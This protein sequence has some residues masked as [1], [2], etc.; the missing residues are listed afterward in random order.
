MRTLALS[1]LDSVNAPSSV[2]ASMPDSA[3]VPV[4]ASVLPVLTDLNLMVVAL[5]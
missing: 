3:V 4:T 1:V 5:P 2:P